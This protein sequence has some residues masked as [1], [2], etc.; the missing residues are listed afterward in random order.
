MPFTIGQQAKFRLEIKGIDSATKDKEGNVIP[1]KPFSFKVD[2]LDY[3]TVIHA[4][5]NCALLAARLN[6]DLLNEI[7]DKL[8]EDSRKS[9]IENID[10]LQVEEHSF[11]MTMLEPYFPAGHKHRLKYMIYEELV[12]LFYYLATGSEEIKS[13]TVIMQELECMQEKYQADKKLKKGGKKKA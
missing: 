7:I 5:K 1:A 4:M 3:P 10:T 2:R 11:L 12:N 9:V 13:L 8:P 6:P